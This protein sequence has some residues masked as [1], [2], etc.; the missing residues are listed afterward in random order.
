M[1]D[2]DRT[3]DVGGILP[4]L[5]IFDDGAAAGALSAGEVVEHAMTIQQSLNVLDDALA[6]V[7]RRPD[8][9]S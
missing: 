1:Q 8:R 6:L 9:H 4:V 5:E 3:L 2:A 7:V